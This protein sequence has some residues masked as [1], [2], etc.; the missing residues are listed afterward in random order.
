MNVTLNIASHLT[1]CGPIR[2]L[3]V[4]LCSPLLQHTH[5]SRKSRST[6]RSTGT[7]GARLSQKRPPAETSTGTAGHT[8]MA[9][10]KRQQLG[11]HPKSAKADG[12]SPDTTRSRL[13]SYSESNMLHP[14]PALGPRWTD[15]NDH[16]TITGMEEEQDGG[17]ESAPETA[18][19]DPHSE[20]PTGQSAKDQQLQTRGQ[21]SDSQCEITPD[22]RGQKLALSA[23]VS[24]EKSSDDQCQTTG[25]CHGGDVDKSHRAA[26]FV[27]RRSSSSTFSRPQDHVLSGTRDTLETGPRCEEPATTPDDQQTCPIKCMAACITADETTQSFSEQGGGSTAADVSEQAKENQLIEQLQLSLQTLTLVN[28][29]VECYINSAFWTVCWAHLLCTHYTKADWMMMTAPF[30]KLLTKGTT[31][32]LDLRGHQWMAEG[33]TQW[34]NLRHGGQQDYSDFLAFMLGWMG[35]NS[36]SQNFERRFEEKRT[37][38]V[39]EKGGKHAPI[40][41]HTELWKNLTEPTPFGLV[42]QSWHEQHGMKTALMVASSIICLQVCRFENMDQPDCRTFDFGSYKF[43]SQAFLCIVEVFAVVLREWCAGPS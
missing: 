20:H 41:L 12:P 25:N 18:P 24:S 13:S 28:N 31:P 29:A 22:I 37:I 23:M 27:Q 21:T 6:S 14:L 11:E 4:W 7:D 10:F 19:V 32:Q 43:I 1:E 2:N 35:A 8:I 15:P 42:I 16:P 5:G 3:I 33:M 17:R 40:T 38:E 39:A 36:V 9:A 26:R 34:H 30:G